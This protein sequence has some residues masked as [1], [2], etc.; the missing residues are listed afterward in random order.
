M[1]PTNRKL[2]LKKF[3]HLYIGRGG[4][5]RIFAETDKT[6]SYEKDIEI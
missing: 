5:G 3:S 4:G 2:M 6:Y 1:P